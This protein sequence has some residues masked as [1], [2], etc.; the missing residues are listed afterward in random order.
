[1]IRKIEQNETWFCDGVYLEWDTNKELFVLTTVE[2]DMYRDED[3]L[4]WIYTK[5]RLTPYIEYITDDE[6]ICPNCGKKGWFQYTHINKSE[7]Y[8]GCPCHDT[9]ARTTPEKAWEEWCK[10]CK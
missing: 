10:W 1:M 8:F 4:H 5:E 9:R 3:Q 7:Y 6:P 2:G